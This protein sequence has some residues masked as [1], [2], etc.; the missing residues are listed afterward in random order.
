VAFGIVIADRAPEVRPVARRFF[1]ISTCLVALGMLTAPVGASTSA[2]QKSSKRRPTHQDYRVPAG[3]PLDIELRSPLGSDVSRPEDPVRGVLRSSL[4][5][6]GVELVPAGAVVFGKV[7]AAE[8]AV[9]KTD[10][11]H[12]AFR[13]DVLEHPATNSRVPIRTEIIVLERVGDP[14]KKSKGGK[15]VVNHIRLD[16]GTPISTS[17]REPFTVRIPVDSK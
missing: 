13:F 15:A 8:A 14:G 4:T 17:L 6:E 11:G 9:R 2:D 5:A 16:A 3:T 10:V 12:L 7:T 1:L